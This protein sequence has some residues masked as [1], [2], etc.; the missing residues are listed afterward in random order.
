MTNHELARKLL[1][2]PEE[3]LE[4]W[5]PDAAEWHTVTGYTYGNGVV[6]LYSDVID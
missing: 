5:D 1:A 2:D 6:R 4:I 3:P